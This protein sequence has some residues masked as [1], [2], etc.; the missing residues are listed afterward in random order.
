MYNIH[1][2]P[3]SFGDSI[4]IEYGTPAKPHYILIDGGP[5]FV[6]QDV[7][8][9]LKRVAP[10]IKELELLVITHI[11]IDHIDGTITLLNQDTLPFPIKEVW[12]NGY[13]EMEMIK[14]DIMGPLQGE[15]ISLV[16]ANKKFSQ[17]T[18]FEQ[19][20]VMVGD[21]SK[22]PQRK[23]DGGMV[24]TLLSPGEKALKKL[25][26]KWKEEIMELE[27]EKTIKKRWADEKRYDDVIDDMDDIL[28][29]STVQKLQDS[30]PKGDLSV[31]NQSSIAFIGKY[32]GKQCLFAGDAT[33]D[34]LLEAITSLLSAAG[35]KRLRLDAWKLAHHGSKGSTL[36][37]LMEKIDCKTM[38]ISSDGKR[39]HHPDP[40]CIAKL[41][42]HSAPGVSF[43]FNYL[44][45]YNKQWNN[46]DW[47]T[48]Y[49]FESYYPG[50]ENGISIQLE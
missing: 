28:G 45:P 20:A 41:I 50:K 4:L 15:Y 42:K 9:G 35:E 48:K 11:D 8:L 26:A 27:S 47:K 46:K 39:Y 6:F 5:Y 24:I 18:Q 19:K 1:L 14:D 32:E 30:N 21:Y 43:Y 22:L 36:D 3:A 25:K 44:T 34:Y 40:E 33:S 7:I 31:A 17:N 37:K 38:L 16:I 49:G 13:K 2:L 23:L 12:F 10:Q 29:K